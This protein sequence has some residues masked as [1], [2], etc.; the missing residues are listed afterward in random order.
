M[1][2]SSLE[3]ILHLPIGTAPSMNRYS[4]RGNGFNEPSPVQ[5]THLS[6][7]VILNNSEGSGKRIKSSPSFNP[8][9]VNERRKGYL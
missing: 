3:N 6:C 2:S 8:N 9:N 7:S 4:R 1:H 5:N